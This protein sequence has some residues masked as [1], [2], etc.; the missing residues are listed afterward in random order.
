[1]L[2]R[3]ICG[4]YCCGNGVELYCGHQAQLEFLFAGLR[5]RLVFSESVKDV[6]LGNGGPPGSVVG[7]ASGW[8]AVTRVLRSYRDDVLNVMFPSDCRVCGGPVIALGEAQVCEACVARVEAQTGAGTLC[9]RCG[10]ALGMESARFAGA[11][12]VHECTMCRMAPPEFD[13]AVA[14]AAYDDEV[15]EML[16]L[17]KFNG[18][19][20][21]AKAVFA[22]GMASAVLQL[23]GLAA[24]ELVVVPVPLFA[25]RERARG[26]NQARLL[27][28]VA[29]MRVKKLRPGWSLAM[30]TDALLRVK[31]T[32]ASFGLDPRMRRKNLRGAF[33]VGDAE[34]V[35][36]REV[37]LVD[38]IMTT[39]ATARECA[40]VLKRAG[41]A[42]VWVVTMARAQE[43]RV[44]RKT[45]VACWDVV[46]TH[47]S[48]ARHGAPGFLQ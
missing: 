25:A 47:V 12:G 19:R 37:L 28:E 10:D 32:N 14:F 31:D 3:L 11:M 6:Q 48:E 20:E 27:A 46:E 43:E 29:L 40:R 17:F 35:R 44:A 1:M 18:M 21:I 22:D 2:I 7:A 15:R 5:G 4:G 45:D 33:R 30:R 38:D 9:R 36:W 8:R 34:A 24:K 13:R 23:E 16:H 42:K 39:G 41:A 26:F